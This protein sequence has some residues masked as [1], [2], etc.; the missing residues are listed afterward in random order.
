MGDYEIAV[1]FQGVQ[2]TD[3]ANATN[4]AVFISAHYGIEYDC[5]PANGS[6]YRVSVQQNPNG[7]YLDFK[8]IE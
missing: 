1:L 2:Y 8:V 3:T 6:K 4:A 7:A 5:Y